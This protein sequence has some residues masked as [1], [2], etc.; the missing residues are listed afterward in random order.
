MSI[1]L[2]KPR[3]VAG[4]LIFSLVVGGLALAPAGVATAATTAQNVSTVLTSINLAR[5]AASTEE[6]VIPALTSSAALT[7]IAQKYATD[8]ATKGKPATEP[9]VIPYDTN[10]ETAPTFDITIGQI[11]S[12]AKA[13]TAYATLDAAVATNATYNFTG[14][15]YA[16]KGSKTFVVALV[17][18]YDNAPV[19]TLKVSKPTLAG[20]VSV[21]SILVPHYSFSSTPD[22]TSFTWYIDGVVNSDFQNA[23]YLP[24]FPEFKGKTIQVEVSGA[25]DGYTPATATS[26]KTAKVALGKLPIVAQVFG[27][28]N[29]GQPLYAQ[30]E[31]VLFF[32][33]VPTTKTYQWYRGSS[34]IS[35]E[36]SNTYAQVAKDSGKK[37]WVRATFKG[38]GLATVTKDSSKSTTTKPKQIGYTSGPSFS[39][40]DETLVIGSVLTADSGDWLNEAPDLASTIGS[41]IKVSYRWLRDGKA[42]TGATKSVY[43]VKASDVGHYISVRVTGTQKNRGTTVRESEDRFI[44]GL[45]F[46]GSLSAAI[47]GTFA[48]GK[49]LTAKVTNLPAGAKVS[50]RWLTI[51]S[52]LKNKAASTSSKLK[53]TK[54]TANTHFV[55]VE[56]TVSKPG[57]NSVTFNP[58][59][60][61]L[62]FFI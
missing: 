41:G 7:V 1:A 48:S 52:Y 59:S 17:A 16:T 45:S 43:T 49:T 42:I 51:E 29:V 32:N 4:A 58:L 34:K 25:K 47:T 44:N 18:D 53:I 11:S 56:I 30:A 60:S 31:A 28:R 5:S 62:P 10:S 21:G 39:S 40:P 57:Y 14:I 54:A 61:D 23:P 15:G 35:G 46:D 37:I 36:T 27:D 26:S 50:Y 22:T 38:D 12:K 33:F 9:T 24:V 2:P 3:S 19:E 8:S 20:T 55:G 13:S 6:A